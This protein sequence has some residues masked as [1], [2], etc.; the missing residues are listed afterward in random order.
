M[1]LT[2]DTDTD[3][4][5]ALEA[6]VDLLTEQLA[7]VTE[8]ALHQRRRRE[9]LEELTAD[10]MPLAT[11]GIASISAELEAADVDL[12][13]LKGLVLHLAASAGRLEALLG[14]L[15]SLSE[16]VAD[17]GPL[18]GDAVNLATVRLAELEAKG[19]FGFVR[20]ASGILDEIVTNYTEEDVAA[21]GENVVLILDTVRQMTQPEVMGLLSSTATAIHDDV[22]DAAEHP[23][24]APSMFSLIGQMRDPEVRLGLQRAMNLLRT[25]SGTTD[26]TTEGDR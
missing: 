19:Y 20:Q 7:I 21:L 16:L 9:S 18:L 12:A 10:V 1:A 26:S 24:E 11:S 25:M 5:A 14:Q 17:A 15:D 13:E 3:R 22:E 6:K 4:L 23:R 8:E 2:H